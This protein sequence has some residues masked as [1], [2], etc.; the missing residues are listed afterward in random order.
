[1]KVTKVVKEAIHSSIQN[2]ADVKIHELKVQNTIESESLKALEN[3]FKICI[4]RA[5]SNWL[6]Q[7][8]KTH[9]HLKFRSTLYRDDFNIVTLSRAI[10]LIG[11]NMPLFRNLGVEFTTSELEKLDK[12]ILAIQ[13]Q[14]NAKTDEIVLAL[15][16]GDKKQTIQDLLDQVSF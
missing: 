14:V 4:Y 9:P 7:V 15:E 10:E 8:T 13:K 3:D 12:D 2:K 1:M 6:E 16:L 5:M 11:E